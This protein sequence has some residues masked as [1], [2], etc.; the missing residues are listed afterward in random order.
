MF[1]AVAKKIETFNGY[2]S[3]GKKIMMIQ[4]LNELYV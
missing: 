2:S 1:C 3:F 4:M